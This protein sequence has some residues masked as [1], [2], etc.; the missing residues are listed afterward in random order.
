M[1]QRERAVFPL[2]TEHGAEDGL[3]FLPFVRRVQIQYVH[4]GQFP[5]AVAQRA[6]DGV[7]GEQDPPVRRADHDHVGHG[8]EEGAE[9]G[10]ALAQGRLGLLL[11]GDVPVGADH[12]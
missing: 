7:V 12:L 2:A 11:G 9:V 3:R 6:H 5:G 4:G 10:L 1:N 8:L